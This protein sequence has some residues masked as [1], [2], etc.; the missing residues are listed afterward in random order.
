[1]NKLVV[2]YLLIFVALGALV[3][4][5]FRGRSPFGKN[6]TSFALAPD[7]EITRIDLIQGD[8]KLSL[9][10]TGEHWLINKKE[11]ARKNAVLFI[12]RT[13]REIKIKSPVSAEIFDSE[14]I[15]KHVE[16]VRVVIYEKRR[17]V[18]SFYVYKT[19]SNVYGN[20]MKMNVS[21]KPFIVFIPGYEATIG[22]HFI[23][24]EL[25]WRP[26]IVFNLLPSQIASVKYENISDSSASFIINCNKKKFS[27]SDLK[28]EIS[29]WDTSRLKRYLTYYTAI[30]FE[31]WAFD[32]SE[33]EKKRIKSS[34]P[35][36]RITVKQTNGEEIILIVWE[37]WNS[38]INDKK[39]DTDKVWA[40]TNLRD[41]VFVMRYFDLD[42]ILKKRSYF[43]TE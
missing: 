7:A 21:S 41:E 34:Q 30:Q 15:K 1:M 37:K 25:F 4:F 39:R 40:M 42:P 19:E 24:N 2:R 20:I 3:I 38:V 16:P 10:K 6:N 18:K 11:E 28:K 5:V 12:L 14:I 26:Y 23:V 29:G 17:L 27:L 31:S 9:G 35:L 8:N 13:L 22:T 43:F 33:I 36:Y 32:L